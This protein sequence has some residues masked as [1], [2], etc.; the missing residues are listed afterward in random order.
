MLSIIITFLAAIASAGGIWINALYKD[1]AFVKLAWRANDIITLFVAAP[2]LV[3]TI[4][5]S[6][7]GSKRWLIVWI[8]L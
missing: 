7:K 6:R 8:G 4:Y 3:I 2:L 5:L 1:N